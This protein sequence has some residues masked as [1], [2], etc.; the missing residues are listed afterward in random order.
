[1]TKRMLPALAAGAVLW[2]AGCEPATLTEARDQL[3]RN[4]GVLSLELPVTDTTYFVTELLANGVDTVTTATGLLGVRVQADTL[5]VFSYREQLTTTQVTTTVGFPAPV[6]GAPGGVQDTITFQTPQ[7]S[8][9]VSASVATGYVVRTTTNNTGCTGT[10]TATLADTS[11]AV[12][13]T[14]PSVT[15]GTG[16]TVIDSVTA[17]GVTVG[18]LVEITA[19]GSVLGGCVPAPGSKVNSSITVRPLTLSAVTLDNVNETIAVEQPQELDAA[20]LNLADLEDAIRQSTINDATIGV[21]VTN[22]ADIP[23]QLSG[24]FLTAVR[25]DAA[26]QL[27]RDGAGNLIFEIDSVTGNR[28]EVA[29]ADPGQTTFALPR[30]G[31][32]SLSVN[33]APVID[34]ILDLLIDSNRVALVAVGNALA[35]DGSLATIAASDSVDVGFDMVL[36]LDFTIPLAGVTIDRNQTA[37]GIDLDSADAD[38]IAARILTASLEAEVVNGTPFGVELDIALAPDSLGSSVDVFTQPGAILLNRVTVNAAPTGAGGLP[39]GVTTDSISLGLSGTQTRVVL[40]RVFTAGMRMRL[41]PRSGGGTRGAIPPNAGVGITA[42][43]LVR[44]RQG[45][46]GQ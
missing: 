36:G 42:S 44:I 1:M 22:T 46:G 32:A 14:F 10:A 34:R 23:V 6:F 31:S 38:D 39:S 13:L 15:V 24:F 29:V 12:V 21:T 8:N 5:N 17:A 33:A 35:G 41:L 37:S 16:T 27:L 4:G 19:T 45:S 7:G 20:E 2:A 28:L 18:A 11:G 3:G 40:T 9:L 25:L 30:Q 26:G 43:V